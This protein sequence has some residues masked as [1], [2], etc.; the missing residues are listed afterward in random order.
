MRMSKS[1][2][3]TGVSLCAVV[4][5][6]LAIATPASGQ[7]KPPTFSVEIAE[8]NCV[9]VPFGPVSVVRVYPG[10][11]LTVEFFLRNWSPEGQQLRGYQTRIDSSSYTSGRAGDAFPRAWA[12]TTELNGPCPSDPGPSCDESC[13]VSN[14]ANAFI[15]R[16]DCVWDGDP[17]GSDFGADWCVDTPC[18]VPG[19]C[20]GGGPCES[21]KIDWVF[22]SVSA[23]DVVDA[24]N[25][26]ACDYRHMS[27]LWN[28]VAGPVSNQDGTKYYLGTVVLKVSADAAGSFAIC[29][30][31]QDSDA[32][33]N[34]DFSF[35]RDV[36]NA[37]ITPVLFECATI[38]VNNWSFDDRPQFIDL[39]FREAV[40]QGK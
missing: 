10:D 2:L 8:V 13:G 19:E 33:G 35:L 9:D 7:S 20:S 21:P 11:E 1:H 23:S 29:L 38:S 24:V 12:S 37:P 3:G 27:V 30:A 14:S 4:A 6:Q 18:D 25:T 36:N 15:D 32:D 16:S 5:I 31:D 34:P 39:V 28:G 17:V 40:R 26:M 22:G